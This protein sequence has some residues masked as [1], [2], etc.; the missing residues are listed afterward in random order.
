[1][2][3]S[4]S[5]ARES[6]LQSIRDGLAA[7]AVSKPFP[8]VEAIALRSVFVPVK[9]SLEEAFA[10][11]FAQLGGLFSYCADS[12]QLLQQLLELIDERGWKKVLCA[13]E[14]LRAFLVS[15]GIAALP[16]HMP[17]EDADACITGC[18]SLI[19]RTGSIMLSSAQPFG[20]TAPVYYPVHIVIARTGQLL[21]DI[22][23]G[24]NAFT[25]SGNPLPSMMHLNTGPSRTADIEKTL[26]VGVHGPGEVFVF[27]VEG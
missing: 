10:G 18:E 6:I 27:L 16:A 7:G 8:E 19:A 24:L 2:S 15:A 14:E 11:N 17:I 5:G 21:E 12:N 9:G 25:Q 20:R 3:D 23:D 22:A 13:D 1:M 26:V 4:K